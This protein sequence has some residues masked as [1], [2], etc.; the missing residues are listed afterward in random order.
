MLIKYFLTLIKYNDIIIK[1]EKRKEQMGKM[2]YYR[3]FDY[4]QRRGMKKSELAYQKNNIITY[5]S[6]A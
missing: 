4:M 6:E 2:M 5:F 1:K 3:L